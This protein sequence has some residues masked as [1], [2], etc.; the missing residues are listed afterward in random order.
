ME[1]RQSR[2]D[3]HRQPPW[4]PAIQYLRYC[5]NVAGLWLKYGAKSLNTETSV[6][7]EIQFDD[8]TIC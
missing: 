2:V 6:Q 7:C 3:E 5:Q 4:H 8:A 1:N